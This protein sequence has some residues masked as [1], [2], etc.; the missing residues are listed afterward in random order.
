M[1]C[2]TLIRALRRLRRPARH[3][4]MSSQPG[5]YGLARLKHVRSSE[6]LV[7]DRRCALIQLCHV[8]SPLEHSRG[9]VVRA[10]PLKGDAA[11]PSPSQLLKT[12]IECSVRH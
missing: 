10:I 3:R 12:A 7:K 9:T 8:W 2:E 11:A 5:I 1:L 6:A 4:A